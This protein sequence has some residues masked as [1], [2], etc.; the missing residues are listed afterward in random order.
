VFSVFA[1]VSDGFYPNEGNL[2]VPN[3]Y[4]FSFPF[5]FAFFFFFSCSPSL[6][7]GALASSALRITE[8]RHKEL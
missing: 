4:L 6:I 7:T 8:M 2:G 5:S 1:V 3:E